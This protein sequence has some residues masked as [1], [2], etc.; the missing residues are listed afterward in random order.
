MRSLLAV[1]LLAAVAGPATAADF[2]LKVSADK[3][4][5]ETAD[6]KPFLVVGDTAW[7]LIAQLNEADI[8]KYLDDRKGRGFNAVIVSLIEHKFADRAPATIAGVQPFLKPGDFTKPNPAYFDTAHKAVAEAGKRGL[9]VWL[10]AAYLGW[11]GGDEGFFQKIKAAG[12]EAL[13]AYGKF[14]GGRFKDLPN[15]VWVIGGDY[16]LPEAERWAGEE[17]A[18]GI[19]DGGAEQLMTAHGGQTTAVDTFG[20]RPWLGVDT[21]YRYDLDL[22]KP[23]R[24]AYARKPVRPFVMFES[25]YEGEHKAAPDRI[26]RQAWWPVLAG[27]CGSFFGNNPIWYFDGPGYT[28]RKAAPTWQQAL[29]LPGSRDV[30]RVG[31]FFRRLPWHRLV[32]DAEDKLVAA[33]GGDGATKATA[34]HTGDRKLAVVYVPSTGKEP[35]ELSLNLAGFPGPVTARW[36]NPAKDANGT[37][38]GPLPNKDGQPVRTPGDN[39][40]GANDWALVLEVLPPPA[41][42]KPGESRSE[43]VARPAGD[44]ESARAKRTAAAVAVKGAEVMEARTFAEPGTGE[45][46]PY[47]LFKVNNPEP[48]KTYPLVLLLHHAGRGGDDNLK[49]IQNDAGVGTFCHPDAQA[50]NP[51][52]V[53]APQAGGKGRP[54]AWSDASWTEPAPAWPEKPNRNM[55]LALAALDAVMKEVPVDPARVYV[56][57]ASMG[58][59]GTHDALTRRPRFFAAAV[60][61]CGG[62][63]PAGAA[64]LTDTPIW[65]FHGDADETTDVDRSRKLFAAVTAA[66]GKQMTYWEYPGVRHVFARDLAYA[67]PRVIDWLFRQ[68]RPAGERKD[69]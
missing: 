19:R 20:D 67:D 31:A 34:A 64:G 25:A 30:A 38:L 43:R 58:S 39:G 54:E 59:Y 48:G 5:L 23:L 15:V 41:G 33:G 9:S 11:G 57:G 7:S 51:C 35:R 4:H 12:P 2:P 52:Y 69:P 27:G 61:I 68:R 50:A 65:T 8:A 49:H 37:P 47:R 18:R 36:F 29:D 1:A 66:G 3:R 42:P 13:R 10:C 62:Y 16:A 60:T 44:A 56:S 14:V 32:P 63:T 17:L 26:R 22:W 21:V 53:L 24:A 6:G 45:A 55:R 28:D 46:M 40:T